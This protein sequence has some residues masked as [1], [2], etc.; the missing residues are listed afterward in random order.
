MRNTA[1]HS[2]GLATL[3]LLGA[4]SAD[5]SNP[6]SP[7]SSLTV[8]PFQAE[9]TGAVT[10]NLRGENFDYTAQGIL[11][12]DADGKPLLQLGFNARTKPEKQQGGIESGSFSLRFEGN[13][14][15]VG[16]YNIPTKSDAS[17]YGGTYAYQKADTLS[18]RSQSYN[19]SSGTLTVT[20]VYGNNLVGTISLK[21]SKS[22]GTVVTNG[23]LTEETANGEEVTVTIAF[24]IQVSDLR[25]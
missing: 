21:A 9:V 4:C 1:F 24:Q 14:L 19:T 13:I 5:S 11:S 18:S 23:Q 10:S 17:T 25:Y 22:Y 7:E 6:T 16:T 20:G 3:L 2:L 15:A 12:N 8:A